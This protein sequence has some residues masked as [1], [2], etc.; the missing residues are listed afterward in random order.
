MDNITDD[1][2]NINLVYISTSLL[3]GGAEIVL[4]QLISK[5]PPNY[6]INVISLSSIGE[7]GER[8]RNLG[9]PVYALNLNSSFP[10]PFQ[11]LKLYRLLKSIKPDIV[12]TWLYH[13]N[14]LGGVIARFAGIK[15]IIWS[16]HHSDVRSS[17]T[18]YK[19]RF[20]IKISAYLSYRIPSQILFVSH[21]SMEVHETI[22]YNNKIFKLIP[23][24]FDITQFYPVIEAYASV[25]KE[26]GLKNDVILVGLIARFDPIKNHKGF[27]EAA[28][29]L[30]QLLPNVHFLL[31]GKDIDCSNKELLT[32]IEEFGLNNKVHL[33][34]LRNDIPR[35]TS[36]LDIAALTSWS[37][38]FPTIVGEAMA[39]SVPCV[40]TDVG[41]ASYMVG[42]CGKVIRIGDMKA[43]ADA[44]FQLLSLSSLERKTI[45]FSARQ[46]VIEK[47]NLKLILIE[48]D[49]LYKKYSCNKK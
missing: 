29:H 13:A 18:R 7:I 43:F 32:W 3:T 25:R 6:K 34:G 40:V 41:D 47:F 2:S 16:I 9:I 28:Y 23:N 49:S 36:A 5:L 39:C 45:G 38:A 24:G 4:F 21:K 12:N 35:L 22:G 19:T 37:E 31:V 42:S 20:I 27:L 46:R 48:Y 44:C 26:L 33:L 30:I 15:N 11:I 8:I 14:M 17:N 1:N 10:N